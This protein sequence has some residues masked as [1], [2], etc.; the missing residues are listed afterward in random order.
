[1]SESAERL[2]VSI[3]R[4]H[5]IPDSGIG[6]QLS[7]PQTRPVY[8]LMPPIH[9]RRPRLRSAAV[10]GGQ[11]VWTQRLPSRVIGAPPGDVEEAVRLLEQM[12]GAVEIAA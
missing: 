5:A 3:Q 10:S 4:V 6:G 1:M 2:G 12:L 9:G 8:A 7:P 11:V